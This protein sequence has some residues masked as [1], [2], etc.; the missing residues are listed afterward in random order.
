MSFPNDRVEAMKKPSSAG[1]GKQVRARTRKPSRVTRNIATKAGAHRKAAT[2]Q[3]A[4]WLEKLGMA[5]YAQR[6]A[7]NDIDASVLPHL[8]DQSLK[9]LGV[10][11]GHRLKILAAIK[12]LGGPPP[13]PQPANP[14]EKKPRD[15]AER[16][17][18]T[19]M[20][21]DLVGSTALSARMDPED[22]REV[23]PPT[24]SALPRLCSALVAS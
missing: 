10:S 15:T 20:F 11:L 6:F 13:P 22:L 17:Q 24:R 1:G 8:T 12:E 21:S 9:E 7:E 19:V 2:D 18:V 14:T 4:D 23:I 3:L 5:E 16:R